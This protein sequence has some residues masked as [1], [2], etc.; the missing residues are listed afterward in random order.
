MK[1]HEG[2]MKTALEGAKPLNPKPATMLDT[3][4]LLLGPL[5]PW[6]MKGH[7]GGSWCNPSKPLQ[8]AELFG[9]LEAVKKRAKVGL[10]LL[11]RDPS[12][13]SF[14]GSF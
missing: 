12:K 2:S 14:K 9:R 4:A 3:S 8:E 13:R 1:G 6:G 11:L 7:L 5:D 10:G